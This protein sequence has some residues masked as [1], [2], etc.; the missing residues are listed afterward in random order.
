[1]QT[2][3]PATSPLFGRTHRALGWKH[4]LAALAFAF[5]GLLSACGQPR[6]QTP[7]KQPTPPPTTPI[8]Q[9]QPPA[10]PIAR[11]L[12]GCEISTHEVGHLIASVKDGLDIPIDYVTASE[13]EQRGVVSFVLNGSKPDR[14][15][16]QYVDRH[17]DHLKALDQVLLGAAAG[18]ENQELVYGAYDDGWHGDFDGADELTQYT[19]KQYPDLADQARALN[20]TKA[21]RVKPI[22]Q[23]VGWET[24]A[25]LSR[26]LCAEHNWD[27]RQ[28]EDVIRQF[29]LNKQGP[30]F[31]TVV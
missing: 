7:T 21:E 9:T 23:S 28:T 25:G 4:T 8:K 3:V 29:H 2:A 17:E 14:L 20:A 12:Q 30:R 22:L 15:F 18:R 26:K 24:N 5:S 1:M 10:S 27:K 6:H 11:E 31:G 13:G 16:K 19:A